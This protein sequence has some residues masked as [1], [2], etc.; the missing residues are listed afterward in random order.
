MPINPLGCA[1]PYAPIMYFGKPGAL[2]AFKLPDAGYSRPYSD[3]FAVH[4]LLE[5]R[6]VDRSPYGQRV[7]DLEH[8]WLFPD[9]TSML[10]EYATRQRGLGPFI[11]IDPHTKNRLSPNQASGTDALRTTEGFT[12]NGSTST[13]IDTFTRS[14]T[15]GWGSTD[16]AQA[17]TLQGTA[18]DFNVNGSTGSIQ[19]STLN[20][21]RL[22]Y[23]T[24]DGGADRT[25]QTTISFTTLPATA[26]IRAGLI[27]RMVDTSNYYSVQLDTVT[28]G[29]LTLNVIKRVAG[30]QT[31]ISSLALTDVI[32][33]GTQWTIRATIS[34]STIT[35][36]AWATAA[37][38][39][40][41]AQITIIDTSLPSGTIVGSIARNETAVTTHIMRFDNF[42]SITPNETLTSDTTQFVRGE[43]SLAW[44]LPGTVTSGVMTL[45]P[46]SGLYGWAT[47][48]GV[49]WAFSGRIKGGGTDPIV[50]VTPLLTWK[51]TLNAV[52]SVVSGTAVVTNS[53]T[54]TS[55]CVTGTAPLDG[56]LN[57][58]F[59]VSRATV[60]APAILYFDELQLEM[61]NACTTWEYGDGQPLV[62]VRVLNETVPRIRR[63]TMTFELV[64]VTP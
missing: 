28:S 47:P 56:F 18:A 46:P 59:I 26:L 17:Y 38:M 63:G 25:V 5:G 22:A 60:T 6:S 57:L 42:T 40:A 35:A 15:G 12:T 14:V 30:V 24:A 32:T 16:T 20:A 33:A 29:A 61:N 58:R 62:S 52:S 3:G 64:E 51:T 4:D 41:N 45:D 53:S 39:P 49:T 23:V 7:W 34:G 1:D 43:T 11:F 54:F 37:A 36:R 19:P 2:T 55:F 9:V 21:D 10:Y 8:Q 27:L 31:I 44:N 50:T 48:N 13:V